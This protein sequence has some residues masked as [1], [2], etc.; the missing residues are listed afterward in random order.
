VR[1]T[2][3]LATPRYAPA[4]APV[5]RR[6]EPVSAEDASTDPCATD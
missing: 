5:S 6:R 3:A 4:D 1:A 2:A